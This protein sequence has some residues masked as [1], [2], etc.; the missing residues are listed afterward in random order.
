MA[1]RV[2]IN[3]INQVSPE[4]GPITN[5]INSR[6]R[7]TPEQIRIYEGMAVIPH[8]KPKERKV[9][10]KNS[11]DQRGLTTENSDQ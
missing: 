3:P 8:A 11:D 7:M 5:S 10:K 9:G 4:S 2:L 6:Y 1:I